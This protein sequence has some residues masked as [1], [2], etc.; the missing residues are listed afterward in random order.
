MDAVRAGTLRK[1]VEI[2]S[3]T[4]TRDGMGGV[5]E[6]WAKH[7]EGRA[8]IEP[9]RGDER[10]AAQRANPDL[11]HVVKMRYREGVTSKMRIKYLDEKTA[12]TRYLL[13][14]SIVDL[15]E[16]H[17]EMHLYCHEWVDT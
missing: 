4:E 3:V 11:S 16:G 12:A 13:I 1:V 10:W 8:S 2:Q 14:D 15:R 6:T 17:W 7:C 5:I 9:F